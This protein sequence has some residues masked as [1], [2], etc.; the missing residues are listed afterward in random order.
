MLVIELIDRRGK[1][2]VML[3]LYVYLYSYRHVSHI[4]YTYMNR[5]HSYVCIISFVLFL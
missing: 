4:S 5:R 3:C 2:F 1:L